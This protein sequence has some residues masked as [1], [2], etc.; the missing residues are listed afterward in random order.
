MMAWSFMTNLSTVEDRDKYWHHHD[1]HS[2]QSLSGIMYL[3]I[4]DDVEDFDTCGTEIAPNGPESDGKFYVKPS[5]YTW[6]I[7]PSNTWH[8]PGIVQSNKY[9]FILA[10]DID[11]E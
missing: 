3:S 5:Y 7:Y 6:L 4:P 2:G 1:K 11:Y 8:R 9:R 10:A